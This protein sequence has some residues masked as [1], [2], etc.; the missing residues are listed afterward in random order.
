MNFLSSQSDKLRARVASAVQSNPLVRYPDLG[1]MCLG[2]FVMFVGIGAVIPIRTI[3][4]REQGASMQEIGWMASAFILGL[5]ISQ[6]PGGWASDKWGRKPLVVGGVAIAGVMCYVMLLNDQPWFFIAIRFIEG[7]ASGAIGPAAN[8]YVLD[9]VP[10]KERGAA[11]GWLGSAFSAGFMMGPAIGGVMVDWLGYAS[12][13][14]YGGTTTLATAL[15]L[16]LKMANRKPGEKPDASIT[17]DEAV[18]QEE[19]SKRQI[20][21]SLF[22][23]A[24]VAALAFTVAGGFAD[25]LF[26]SIWS[27]WLNDLHASNSYI[28]FTFITFSL[29]VM[30]LMPIT[31]KMADKYPLAPLIAVPSLLISFA[32]LTYGFTTN[33]LFIVVWGLLEGTLVAIYGPALSAYIAN[34]SPDK[35]RGRL[36]GVVSTSRTVAGFASSLL[37]SF[38]YGINMAYPFF[39]IAGVQLFIGVVGG[40]LIWQIERLSSRQHPIPPVTITPERKGGVLESAAK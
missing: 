37:V 40:L 14:I 20:P 25:G 5:F 28:G 2:V 10:A 3:Y 27:I 33:L 7:L 35:A 24:L 9:T 1:L 17:E 18:Q 30:V 4:A 19:K 38:L 36:Q 32:Y 8:A 15:F 11:Y 6:L 13:F 39:M 29:P 23:P 34:L 31:G 26:M 21:R 16:G 22:K 12:P